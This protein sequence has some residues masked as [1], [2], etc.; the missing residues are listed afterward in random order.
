MT[1]LSSY[2]IIILVNEC[3]GDIKM[4]PNPKNY[5]IFPSVVPADKRVTMTIVPN[6][7]AFLL[8]DDKDY[9]VTIIPVDADVA[10]RAKPDHLTVLNL[11]A[12]DGA[13]KFDFVFEREQ[14]HTVILSCEG[15]TLANLKIFSLYEDLY[16]LTP[17]RG[18]LHVHSYRSDGL[19]DPSAMLGHYR[20]QGYDFMTMS[21]HNRYYP[22]GEINETYRDVKLGITHIHGEEVHIPETP[23]HIVHVGGNRSIA[24]IYI[25]NSPEYQ[26]EMAEFKAK[27]PTNIK[28]QYRDRYGMCE[29]VAAKAHEFGGI[30]IFPHPF[31]KPGDSKAHNV[32]EELSEILL[33]AGFFDAY[34]LIGGMSQS[35]NNKSVGFWAE[36]RANGLNIPVVG[37][38]DVHNVVGSNEFPHRFT[39]AFA[40]A[41]SEKDIIDAVKNGLSLAVESEGTEYGRT[42]RCYGSYRLVSY[43]RFL[44]NEYFPKL[45]RIC[46]GEGV[47]MR[48][49][50]MGDAD[51]A[52]IELQVE[53]TE[54]FKNKFFG[55]AE[56]GV[57][58]PDVIDF[59]NRWRERHLRG[60]ITKGSRIYDD[61]ISRQM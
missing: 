39:I 56:V 38:S 42:Y 33:R 32:C 60:P 36:L 20:E 22:G 61:K 31:W 48:R 2:A 57:P 43:G 10:D 54:K 4:L 14:E 53:Q 3:K 50:A 9:V 25:E 7:K 55:K 5:S 12:Q 37:S 11:K 46:Q 58:S 26:K 1:F 27:A 23:I 29:W 18:D 13:L 30:A 17:L 52:L 41:T 15:R 16:N 40:E 24:E 34:E 6:E 59:E 44:L 51:A 21:D 49:Y 35:D 8:F 47:A 19:H 45:Q 28:E